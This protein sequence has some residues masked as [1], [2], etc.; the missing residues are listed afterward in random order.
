ME[1]A[2]GLCE[3]LWS[4]VWR[5][6]WAQLFGQWSGRRPGRVDGWVTC[7]IVSAVVSG[8]C[9]RVSAQ[10]AVC[11]LRVNSENAAFRPDRIE[12]TKAGIFV[13]GDGPGL[14]R[15]NE[16]SQFVPV[17]GGE[18]I[19]FASIYVTKAGTLLI[20]DKGLFRYD[21]RGKLVPVRGGES[22]QYI[23]N[24]IQETKAGVF[25]TGGSRVFRYDDRSGLEPVPGGDSIQ[26]TSKLFETKAALLV[27]T[28]KGQ[29]LRYSEQLR[30]VPVPHG[31][32]VGVVE[33]TRAGVLVTSPKGLYRFDD[34]G[35]LI[36][37]PGGNSVREFNAI[38]EFKA[39]TF[40]VSDEG[41]LL[42]YDGSSRFVPVGG[43]QADLHATMHETS[44]GIFV[45][46]EKGLLR[47]DE[48]AGLVPVPGGEGVNSATIQDMPPGTLV[49]TDKGLF[50]YDAAL[51]LV[52]VP[53]GNSIGRFDFIQATKAGVFFG[54][55]K[56]LYRYDT[57]TGL[58]LV[59]G[60][61]LLK[62]SEIKETKA[63]VLIADD[64]GLFRYDERLGL[65]TVP[66]A[67]PEGSAG[68]ILETSI[69]IFVQR[70]Y[71]YRIVDRPLTEA[72][73]EIASPGKTDAPEPNQLGVPTRWSLNHPCA[74]AA[75]ALGLQVVSRNGSEKALPPVGVTDLQSD[76]DKLTF[77]A[78]VPVAEQGNWSFQV[79]S[80]TAQTEVGNPQ[81]V[82]FLMPGAVAWLTRWWRAI[83]GSL[84]VSLTV[85]NLL[86]FVAARYSPTAWRMATDE[87]WGKALLV[88][89]LLLRYWR[90]AQLWILDLYVSRKREALAAEAPLEFLPL[91]MARGDGRVVSSD[92]VLALFREGRR[93]WVQGNAG[94]G[95]STLFG[96]LCRE[97]FSR[98]K[99]TSFSIDG[100]DRFV[101]VPIE[102]RRFAGVVAGDKGDA[103]SWMMECVRVALSGNGLSFDD[104]KLL[105]AMFE[106]GT[107]GVA[108]DGL[109]EVARGPE[110]T[111]FAERFAKTAM[112]VTSQDTG[113]E[114][115]GVW[116][117]PA[118]IAEYVDALL[119]LYLKEK[120]GLA[121]AVAREIR[122]TG[123]IAHLRS[124]YDVRL[125]ANL[126][127]S[128]RER[129]DKTRSQLDL[130]REAVDAAW[131]KGDEHKE[132]RVEVLAAAAWVLVSDRG[133]NKDRR[134]MVP[135]QDCPADLLNDL[136]KVS[137]IRLVRAA[138]TDYEF[139]HDQMG[140][141]L[142]A[143][144]FTSRAAV[145]VM[146]E[147]LETS[148]VWKVGA[149][150]QRILWSFVAEIVRRETL[151]ALW[152]FAGDEEERVVLW[153]QLAERAGRAGW[154]L[155][156]PA[157]VAVSVE[158]QGRYLAR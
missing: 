50:R 27:I 57:R 59:P 35:Q 30:F 53:G 95:K 103:T 8:A 67:G 141:Y 97:H 101:M 66:M 155:T 58:V 26:G 138:G 78:V 33:D 71:L 120:P 89:G 130:Y 19:E 92:G 34:G 124:G 156:K 93:V 20:G 68:S 17:P 40:I 31:E 21:A 3:L 98:E 63:G 125:V 44:T 62:K 65:V 86:V 154:D 69:G 133:P 147:L 117:L 144:W 51:G 22:I 107:L 9:C 119:E 131:P 36:P 111:A 48:Q 46:T 24:K 127:I 15:Y 28:G 42:R 99:A 128:A 153:K 91:P 73:V 137:A 47:Y 10:E 43:R 81:T 61:D 142:A 121:A 64:K 25:V 12:E 140:A 32:W 2:S 145:A 114:P 85:L 146:H 102:A 39:G 106:M 110:V 56:G 87:N 152:I 149:E 132:E 38:Y 129:L 108:V 113:G 157:A 14:Y 88:Q 115:F 96:R 16:R 79:I 158:K 13:T 104:A 123:L 105:K 136:E 72:V 4:L 126:A 49:E 74:V 75:A 148:Q 76:G 118:T 80:S 83:T 60:G 135:N 100:R 7:A 150:A 70:P 18:S 134:R 84:V 1:I 45:T 29:L 11:T 109:N 41:R 90:P 139:V 5:R 116:R 143:R 82:K 122:E 52:H 112:F 94:M 77:R 6:G 23:L 37:V 54:S 151:T 55:Q